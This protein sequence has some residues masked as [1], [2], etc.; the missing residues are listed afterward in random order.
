MIKFGIIGTGVI[1]VKF[2]NALNAVPDTKIEA[3]QD[4]IP[5]SSKRFAEARGI[6][7]VYATVEE[8]AADPEIDVVYIATINPAHYEIAKTCLNAGKH[9]YCEKPFVMYKA[10]AEELV[11]L[12]RSK[13]LLLCEN[14]WT[15]YLPIYDKVRTLLASG[16]I[17]EVRMI[18]CNYYFPAEFDPNGRLFDKEKGGG[19]LLDIGAY[20][21]G[22][23]GMFM[24]YEPDKYVGIANMGKSGVDERVHVA[25]KYGDHM[26]DITCAITTPAPQKAVIVGTKGRMEFSEFGRAQAGHVW[27]YGDGKLDANSKGAGTRS[28]VPEGGYDYEMKYPFE[29]NG[30]EYIIRAVVDAVKNGKVELEKA[31][32]AE[33][34]AWTGIK[35]ELAK[36]F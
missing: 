26:A 33:I 21:L 35:E 12:A 32:H 13:G 36:T 15:K 18:H 4:I 24:G 6:E 27:V 20:G 7:K 28:S 17:G 19:A 14:L 16:E 30:F 23:V 29:E 22:F 2:A 25:L 8:L 34:I 1:S 31:T 9:V 5:E 3:V 11:A 10:Q